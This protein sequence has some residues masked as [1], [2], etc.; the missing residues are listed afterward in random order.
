MR[1]IN[2]CLRLT[3]PKFFLDNDSYHKR[4]FTNR[5]VNVYFCDVLIHSRWYHSITYK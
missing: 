4:G 2:W 3:K 1:K 5:D